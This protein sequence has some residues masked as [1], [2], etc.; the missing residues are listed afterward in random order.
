[1]NFRKELGVVLADISD[2]VERKDYGVVE[3]HEGDMMMCKPVFPDLYFPLG[4]G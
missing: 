3:S 1:M 2:L 4:G